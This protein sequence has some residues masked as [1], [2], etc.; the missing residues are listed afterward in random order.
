MTPTAGLDLD[1][2]NLGSCLNSLVKGLHTTKW[3]FVGF[4][5]L[6]R[7]SLFS[8]VT[9]LTGFGKKSSESKC[10]FLNIGFWA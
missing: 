3:R 5:V 9:G 6:K 7:R 10:Q 1:M 2:F 8:E 4:V